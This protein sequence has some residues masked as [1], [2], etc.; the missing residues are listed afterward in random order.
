MKLENQVA[1]IT[2]AGAGI[3]EAAALLFAKEGAK[4]GCNSLLAS[5]IAV[6]DRIHKEGGDA[7]FIE[8]DASDPKIAQ[9]I[10]DKTVQCYGRLD[11]LINNVGFVPPGRVD[12]TSVE[13]WDKT[14]VINVR[15]AFIVSKC[16]IPQLKKSKGVIIMTGS[17]VAIR[18]VK[19]R[20]VYT[21]SKGAIVSLTRAMAADYVDDGIR[22]NCICPGTVDSPSLKQRIAKMPDPEAGRIL[23]VGRQPMKRFGT[24]EEIAEGMLYLATAA[25]CTGTILS[26]DGGMTM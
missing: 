26:V 9:Q 10:I 17:S 12:N 25:F 14:M 3:G 24:P 20:A 21:A 11:I 8:G 18:G 23:M 4:V 1:I 15:S 19:D 5:E 13:D 16:A 6:V 2:G 22:V 7:L